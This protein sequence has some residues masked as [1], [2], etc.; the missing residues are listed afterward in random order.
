M[1]FGFFVYR[2]SDHFLVYETILQP[3][4]VGIKALEADTPYHIDFSFRAHLARG[5]Y[6][7][8]VH[9]LHIPTQEFLC[10]LSP[11]AMLSVD[12]QRT[13]AGVADLELAAE[14]VNRTMLAL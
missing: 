3:D 9:V 7:V 2:S 6:Y 5:Q 12:E 11:A 4:E 10:R 13:H 8:G 1:A 14:L